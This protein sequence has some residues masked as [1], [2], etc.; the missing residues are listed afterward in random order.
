MGGAM[1]LRAGLKCGGCGKKLEVG[2]QYIEGTAAEYMGKDV[3]PFVGDLLAD[4]L[5]GNAA[6]DGSTGGKIIYCED[7]TQTGGE[8]ISAEKA[9]EAGKRAALGEF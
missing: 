2:D 5:G 3:D 4:L 1:S 6:L 8:T 7:C 9:F